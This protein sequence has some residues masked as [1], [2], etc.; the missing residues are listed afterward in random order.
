MKIW[1]NPKLWICKINVNSRR[2]FENFLDIDGE[3]AP[4]RLFDL[5]RFA[6]VAVVLV[7][8]VNLI[9][10]PNSSFGEW[11][12]FFGGVLNPILTF[13]M[14]MGLLITIVLQQREL[15]EARIQFERSANALINQGKISKHGAFENTF[16]E[17]IS[18]FNGV[19]SQ[20]D[21]VNSST[22]IVTSGR[23]CFSV[24][25]TRL[26]KEYRDRSKKH[27]KRYSDAEIL[28]WSFDLFLKA[29]QQDLVHYFRLIST[30]VDYANAAPEYPEKYQNILR[31]LLSDREV[32]LLF[33]FCV[34][35]KNPELKLQVEKFGMLAGL[36][37]EYLLDQSHLGLVDIS[38]FGKE[39]IS[40]KSVRQPDG[41][42]KK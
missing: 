33:Y 37:R 12:D 9:S 21:L 42:R 34:A 38:A 11:G 24:F 31:A 3:N 2:Y 30:I 39:G 40:R 35:G 14:F 32:L 4:K 5:F 22:K 18:V 16:F 17:L 28:N 36:Q 1:G 7:F 10:I 23:D 29:N 15:S 26:N 8:C 27:K 25:Y 41:I 13:I 6:A 20:I 19:V